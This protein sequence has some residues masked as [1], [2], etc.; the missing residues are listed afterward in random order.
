MTMKIYGR[1]AFE[2]TDSSGT[3]HVIFPLCTYS[4]KIARRGVRTQNTS[5]DGTTETDYLYQRWQV[6]IEASGVEEW[7]S[8]PSTVTMNTL[9]HLQSHALQG[10]QFTFY[11]HW[12]NDQERPPWMPPAFDDCTLDQDH[13]FAYVRSAGAAQRW[14]FSISF[15]T[16]TYRTV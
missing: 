6:S 15:F 4:V 13:E 10:F 5:L 14:D 11:P 1:P 8:T 16:N 7:N 12:A 2:Y 3:H 9:F